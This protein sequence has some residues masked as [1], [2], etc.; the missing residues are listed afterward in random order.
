MRP[1][2]HSLRTTTVLWRGFGTSFC[3]LLDSINLKVLGTYAVKV[4][5]VNVHHAPCVNE[6]SARHP[7]QQAGN[8][9][10]RLVWGGRTG[11]KGTY[12]TS[13]LWMAPWKWWQFPHGL[14]TVLLQPLF[15]CLFRYF[16]GFPDLQMSGHPVGSDSQE[17]YDIWQF[18]M[19]AG[20]DICCLTEQCLGKYLM[21][22]DLKFLICKIEE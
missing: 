16:L 22:L 13:A 5:N 2:P 8:P 17:R 21:S 3:F 12:C 9:G 11:R 1:K 19:K 14:P 18:L 4:M 20:C 6:S 10:G 7:L 15:C